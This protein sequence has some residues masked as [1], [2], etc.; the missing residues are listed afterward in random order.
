VLEQHRRHHW[1]DQDH[2]LAWTVAV[3]EGRTED[4]VVT[5]YGGTPGRP[6]GLLT[7]EQAWVPQD[8]FGRYFHL[9]TLTLGRHVVAIENNGW[10][11]KSADLAQRVSAKHGR[12]FSVHW[13]PVATHITQAADGTIIADF[14]PLDAAPPEQP[15]DRLPPWL[16][17][18]SFTADGLRS[19]ML[20]AMEQQ[21]G[22][23]FDRQWLSTPLP[24]YRIPAG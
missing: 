6:T 19:T 10:T 21:T 9:Q 14:E 5:L 1:A 18:V 7:F 8:D 20:V 16:N 24:T 2:D 17:T 11:G 15:G 23:A 13:S 4:E 22:L 3:I 12:F